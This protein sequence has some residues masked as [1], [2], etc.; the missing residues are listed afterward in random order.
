MDKEFL[1]RIFKSENFR[2]EE[3]ELVLA[4]YQPKTFEKHDYLIELGSKAPFYYW[5]ESGFA[6][7]YAIDTEGN[8]IST[9]F[10][11]SGDIIID[12]HS[13]FL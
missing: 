3:L 1:T 12:W 9:K 8:D 11:S 13:F 4:Q 5:L 2:S 10:F 7:S 6:R